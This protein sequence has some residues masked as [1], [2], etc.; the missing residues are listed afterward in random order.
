MAIKLDGGHQQGNKDESGMCPG[1]FTVLWE[2]EDMLNL[3]QVENP[4]RIGKVLT[5]FDLEAYE[6]TGTCLSKH[7]VFFKVG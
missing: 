2:A 3:I 5:Q 4:K 7:L 1:I 6:N